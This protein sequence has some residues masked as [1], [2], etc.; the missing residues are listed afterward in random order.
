MKNHIFIIIFL[1]CFQPALAQDCSS[2]DCHDNV[3]EKKYLHVPVEEG[4][5]TACHTQTG[6]KHPK[7]RGTEFELAEKNIQDL[8]SAC[9]DVSKDNEKLHNPVASGECMSCHDPHQSKFSNLLRGNNTAE[10]CNK[11]HET[12]KENNKFVHGPVAVG[13]CNVCHSGH[14]NSN[15]SLLFTKDV[16]STCYECHESKSEEISSYIFKHEPVEESCSNCH[17]PHS[18]NTKYQLKDAPPALCFTCHDS[19]SA[20]LEKSLHVHKAVEID[21]TCL[22][23]HS[24][25]GSSIEKNLRSTSFELCLGC[26]NKP[27]N[28]NKEGLT[29]M[30]K[31]LEEQQDWH[32]P[33]KDKNCTGCH[34]PH[35]SD[36]FRLLKYN[37]P[38]SFYSEFEIE[39]YD[40]CNQCH[41]ATNIVNKDSPQLTN[42]RDGNK[43]LHFLHVNK[44]KG[45]TCRACHETHASIKP[46]HIRE[47]VPFGKW[48]LPV[49]FSPN[50]TGGSCAPGCHVEKTYSR[51][52]VE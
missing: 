49:N 4:D 3:V 44:K 37:Y 41:F 51:D 48:M 1:A 13:A 5:C 10:V 9:H 27:K 38:K 33:I 7:G 2:S 11:C 14:D 30:Q 28:N 20:E 50:E 18:S 23:C 46:F 15:G 45:R 17:N 31:L 47:E 25:H 12:G 36:L 21:N 52:Q 6:K 43:N 29:N 16:N 26:H 39:K 32:G 35:S 22:N 19:I 42:F 24:P 34:Q 40:L 8:C